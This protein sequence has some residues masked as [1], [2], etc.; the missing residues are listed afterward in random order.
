MNPKDTHANL[1]YI[2]TENRYLERQQFFSQT[3]YKYNT[4][5]QES[6]IEKA[7]VRVSIT[8][9]FQ[10]LKIVRKIFYTSREFILLSTAGLSKPR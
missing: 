1:I 2:P 10:L 9:S 3:H 4:N 7:V 5:P 6:S 8:C